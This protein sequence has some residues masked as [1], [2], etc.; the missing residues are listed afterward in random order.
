M[1]FLPEKFKLLFCQIFFFDF[2]FTLSST[3]VSTLALWAHKK[4]SGQK[5]SHCWSADKDFD[6][7][8]LGS[9]HMNGGLNL[10]M[11]FNKG[12][13]TSGR[14][15]EGGKGGCPWTRLGLEFQLLQ[16][17][18]MCVLFDNCKKTHTYFPVNGIKKDWYRRH[19]QYIRP[20]FGIELLNDPLSL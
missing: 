3:L 14:R 11:Q 15:G 2:C 13:T 6:L 9:A 8:W 19:R 10:C 1:Q 17:I 16:N 18:L 5:N 20:H 7:H 12:A 4:V